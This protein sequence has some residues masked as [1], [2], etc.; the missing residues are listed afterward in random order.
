MRET[1]DEQVA[2]FGEQIEALRVVGALTEKEARTWVARVESELDVA[3]DRPVAAAGTP[4]AARRLLEELLAPSARGR[5]GSAPR[6]RDRSPFE[7]ALFALRECHAISEQEFARW[8]KRFVEHPDLPAQARDA[9]R[10]TLRRPPP[11]CSGIEL[12]RVLIAPPTPLGGDLRIRHVEIYSDGLRLFWRRTGTGEPEPDPT[13]VTSMRAA[14]QT[15]RAR[16][17]QRA[18]PLPEVRDDL[19]MQYSGVAASLD[20]AQ[21]RAGAAVEFETATYS[22]GVQPGAKRLEIA[23]AG[24]VVQLALET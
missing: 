7:H 5:G 20:G 3:V 15:R 8:M 24:T 19:G 9:L 21:R 6:R 4:D 1:R 2:R 13:D 22:P 17:R 14:E 18:R 12:E 23:P 10:R 16:D 11:P